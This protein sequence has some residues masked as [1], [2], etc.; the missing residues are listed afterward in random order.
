[1]QSLPVD[2]QLKILSKCDFC[3]HCHSVRRKSNRIDRYFG[4]NKDGQPNGYGHMKSNTVSQPCNEH[5]WVIDTVLR[6]T[7]TGTT[8]YQCL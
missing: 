7:G 2:I 1:M 6:L 4:A 8:P 3:N 5:G